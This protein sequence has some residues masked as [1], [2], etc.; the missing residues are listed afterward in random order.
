MRNALTLVTLFGL[1]AGC[2]T[3]GG[4]TDER[5]GGGTTAATATRHC[6]NNSG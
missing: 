5:T 3:T 4:K 1:W 2:A 6:Q